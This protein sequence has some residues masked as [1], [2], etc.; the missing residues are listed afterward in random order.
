MSIKVSKTVTGNEPLTLQEVK[1]WI[2]QDGTADD[3]LITSL[4]TQSRE[5]IEN[6]LCASLVSTTLLVEATPRTELRPP[7]GPVVTITSVKDEDGND[8]D[9]TWDGFTLNFTGGT[10][11]VT[12]GYSPV[13]TTTTYD[14]GYDT[15]PEGLKMAMLETIAYLYEHRGEEMK[16]QMFLY[17]N[18]NLQPYRET[19]WI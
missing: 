8:V 11:S 2:K 17:Q 16:I 6:Y 14:A 15:L 5:L 7:F 3:A 13:Y 4:I 1:D 10:F 19:I 12:Q 9:Y 18:Q